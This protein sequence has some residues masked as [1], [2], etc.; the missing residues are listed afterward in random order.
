M[1]SNAATWPFLER[2]EHFLAVALLLV[3]LGLALSPNLAYAT[4]FSGGGFESRMENLQNKFIDVIL[5]IMSILGLVYAGILAA[6][7]NEGAKGKITIIIEGSIIGF[8]AP[9]IIGWIKAI[10]S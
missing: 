5:P 1:R 7:G 9:H 6:S 3:M 4:D 10:L 2:V 8:L